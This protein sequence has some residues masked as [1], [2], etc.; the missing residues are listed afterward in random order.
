MKKKEILSIAQFAKRIGASRHTVYG[1]IYRGAD[2]WPAGSK[3]VE[4]A[5]KYFVEI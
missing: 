3:L 2:L 1:W 4:I 5:G